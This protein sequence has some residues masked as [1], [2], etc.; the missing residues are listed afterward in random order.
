MMA[1]FCGVAALGGHLFPIYLGFKGG[2]GVATGAGVVFALNWLAG[3]I[4]LGAFGFVFAVTRVVSLGSMVAA[5]I[6]PVAAWFTI[7]RA[8]WRLEEERWILTAFLALLA[9]AILVRHRDNM[10]RLWRGEESTFRFSSK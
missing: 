4:A 9:V 2:K 6:L 7:R 8:G 1:A 10:R 5:V 3:V